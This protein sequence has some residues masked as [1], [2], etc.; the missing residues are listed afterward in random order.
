MEHIRA[1]EVICGTDEEIHWA[2][3]LW[4]HGGVDIDQG[5]F[6]VE[7]AVKPD[8]DYDKTVWASRSGQFYSCYGGISKCVLHRNCVEFSLTDR[9]RDKLQ[10]SDL[11]IDFELDAVKFKELR[12]I[13]ETVFEGLNQ[14]SVVTLSSEQE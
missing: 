13:L 4:P 11:A 6:V 2:Q 3:W 8:S 14:L 10:C 1:I 9:G 12:E 7:R 5:F